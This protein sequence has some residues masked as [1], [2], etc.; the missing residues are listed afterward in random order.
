MNERHDTA[1]EAAYLYY[2]EN[3]TMEQIAQHLY[4]SRATV[5]RLLKTARDTGIVQIRLN[6]NSKPQT[7]LAQ[8]LGDKYRVRVHL[9]KTSKEQSAISRMEKVAKRGAILVD[10]CVEEGTSLGVAWGS[11]VTELAKHLP[12]RPLKDVVVVQLNGAGNARHTGI[13]YSGSILGQITAAYDAQMV[14]FPVPAFFDHSETKEAMWRE[15][16][17]M[18]VLATQRKADVAVFGIGAF[19]GAIPSHVYNG[20][21]FDAQ[22]QRELRASGVVGDMCTVLLREDGSYQDLAV[23][24]RATGPTATELARIRRRIAV[25]SGNHRVFALRGALRTG[26]ITDVVI[27]TQLA[28]ALMDC[29]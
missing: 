9:V 16:S 3:L 8:R 21:Y 4:T 6:E 1:Y 15:R 22:E 5:S 29:P 10:S 13:P 14:H 11:T 19:G 23:N 17:I 26:A 27:D 7:D 20:G 24:Q 25:V 28:E 18:G 2:M 12:Y